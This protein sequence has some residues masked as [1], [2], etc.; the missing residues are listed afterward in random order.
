LQS[1]QWRREKPISWLFQGGRRGIYTPPPK[2]NR[3][4]HLHRLKPVRP[5][6]FE[7]NAG[8]KSRLKQR[9]ND[10]PVRLKP[11]LRPA[12]SGLTGYFWPQTG[13]FWPPE[14]AEIPKNGNN[15]SIR[16]PFSMILG[17]LESQQQALQ[18]YAEKHHSP[19]KEDKTKL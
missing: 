15:L 10:A 2:S 13:Y 4:S 12:K 11:A 19:T 7:Q 9:G 18:L 1:Q 8:Q 16:T 3:Y 14:I 5:A 6:I 17:S